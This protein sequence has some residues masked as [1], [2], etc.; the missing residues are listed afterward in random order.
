MLFDLKTRDMFVSRDVVFYE[1]TFPYLHANSSTP[2]PTQP[3]PTT[4]NIIP[5]Y[6]FLLEGDTHPL[7]TTLPTLDPASSTIP[8]QT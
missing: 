6:E 1:S 5:S 3:V 4:S 8:S 2:P 7:N